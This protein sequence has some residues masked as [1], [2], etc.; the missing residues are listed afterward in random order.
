MDSHNAKVLVDSWPKIMAACVLWAFPS[1]DPE[2]LAAQ[3]AVEAVTK[4]EGLAT[5]LH[6][7]FLKRR[8]L[9]ARRVLSGY[10]G[11]ARRAARMVSLSRL[12]DLIDDSEPY[13]EDDS[14]DPDLEAWLLENVD[15]GEP[16]RRLIETWD[17]LGTFPPSEAE[18]LAMLRLTVAAWGHPKSTRTRGDLM[19][20]MRKVLQALAEK[21]QGID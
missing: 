9:D 11:G 4:A 13:S 14:A 18:K 7:N 19:L 15:S 12:P 8:V 6:P 3:I 2:E 10:K 1:E 17:A 21:T 16:L 20:R 5:Y